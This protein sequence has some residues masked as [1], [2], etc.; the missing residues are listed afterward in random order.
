MLKNTIWYFSGTVISALLGLVSSPLLTRILSK[1]IFAQYGL[2]TSL[3]T[4]LATFI[5]L[6][7]DESFMRFFEKRS[8]S[9]WKF[10]WICI[11][12]PLILCS[13][14]IIVILEPNH[15][16]LNYVFKSSISGLVA[17][18]F[19]GYIFFLLIQRFLMLTARME[20]RAANYAISNV[21]TK[22]FFIIAIVFVAKTSKN[23]ELE[24]ILFSL[25][26][27][28]VIAILLNVV[29]VLKN[30]HISVKRNENISHKDIF[31][32]GL[33]YTL[34]TTTF[35]IIPVLEKIWIRDWANWNIL[36][37]YTSGAVFITAM[38]LIKVT[39]NNVWVPYVYK[40]Y[41]IEDKFKPLFHSFGVTLCWICL[42]VLAFVVTFRR[43]LVLVFDQ[44]YYDCRLIAPALVCGVCFDLLT[45]VYAIGIVIEKK[46]IFQIIVPFVQ[47]IVSIS[48][49]YLLLPRFGLIASGISYL[50]SIAI[51]RII[52]IMIGLHYYG[53]GY[54]YIKMIVIMILSTIVGV[55]AC[56]I[57]D[58]KFDIA[59]G[60]LLFIF[61]SFIAK[62]ELGIIKLLIKK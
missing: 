22:L 25:I 5:Y 7:Q 28:I 49:L 55:T 40:Y 3:S 34:S 20:E 45:C 11:R 12:V 18:L 26:L 50:F 39:V 59:C 41:M 10:L 36:A 8:I 21:A 9:Y 54:K 38:G 15:Y 27:G 57:S 42:C 19:A 16:V 58:L 43:W 56:F 1:E 17:F 35:W 37:I 24:G 51:S 33:P 46:T 62:K 47:L 44:S 13:V 61:G 52:Q 23:V 30:D 60:I 53:T 29:A 32:F 14:I 6:G 31:L 2:V 4:L 48:L